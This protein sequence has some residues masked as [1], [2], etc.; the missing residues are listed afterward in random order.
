MCNFLL[1]ANQWKQIR[2]FHIWTFSN[3]PGHE[4]S[5]IYHNFMFLMI[6]GEVSFKHSE[7][8]LLKIFLK[9]GFYPQNSILIL[10]LS[11]VKCTTCT[12]VLMCT[13]VYYFYFVV[14]PF[15]LRFP[16]DFNTVCVCLFTKALHFTI[17]KNNIRIL[18]MDKNLFLKSF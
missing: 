3:W 13:H 6:L 12:C 15:W 7:Q 2:S 5:E 9:R 11:I 14:L 10:F 4:F 16:Q 1:L 8:E 18:F 17:D